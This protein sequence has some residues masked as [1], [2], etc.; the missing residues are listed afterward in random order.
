MSHL[1]DILESL[2]ETNAEVKRPKYHSRSRDRDVLGKEKFVLESEK[3]SYFG[4]K[5]KCCKVI[6]WEGGSIL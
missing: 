5:F 4:T 1:D 3:I 2:T 6:Y